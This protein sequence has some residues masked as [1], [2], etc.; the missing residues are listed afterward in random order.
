M[1]SMTKYYFVGHDN[2]PYGPVSPEEFA[3]WGL[4]P[5]TLVCP[6]GGQAWVPLHSVPGLSAWLQPGN[7]AGVQTRLRPPVP[8]Y[9]GTPPPNHMAWSILVTIFCCLPFGIVA[10]VKSSKVNGL[11]Y[12]GYCDESRRMSESARNWCVGSMAVSLVAFICQML[13]FAAFLP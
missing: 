4:T 13:F 6:V 12:N 11:W 8:P 3:K 5:D 1:Y 7:V 2:R 9:Q 10:I